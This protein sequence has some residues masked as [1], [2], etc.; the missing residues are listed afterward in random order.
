MRFTPDHKLTVAEHINPGGRKTNHITTRT[1]A[2]DILSFGSV[3]CI[4]KALG[5]PKGG[6][7]I[8][9]WG[10]KEFFFIFVVF[11]FLKENVLVWKWV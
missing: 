9:F 4:L 10:A 11:F 1:G 3:Y 6:G 7:V 2:N 8:L 5:A